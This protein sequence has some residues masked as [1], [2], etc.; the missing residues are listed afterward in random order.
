MKFGRAHIW[1]SIKA[2]LS[3]KQSKLDYHEAAFGGQSL[4]CLIDTVYLRIQSVIHRLREFHFS[5][6]GFNFLHNLNN[7]LYPFQSLFSHLIISCEERAGSIKFGGFTTKWHSGHR[8]PSKW[9]KEV[10]SKKFEV[11]LFAHTQTSQ[12]LA[13]AS[14]CTRLVSEF[15]FAIRNSRFAIQSQKARISI[16]N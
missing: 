10:L 14:L 11:G 8:R 9:W 4:W 13:M 16:H 12:A 2:T 7:F 5:N 6:W 3:K 1:S 15:K